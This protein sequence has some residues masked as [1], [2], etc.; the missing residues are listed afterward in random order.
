[1]YNLTYYTKY[2]GLRLHV[3]LHR[4]HFELKFTFLDTAD[5]LEE[6]EKKFANRK[7][8]KRK[9]Y[10]CYVVY[11]KCGNREAAKNIFFNL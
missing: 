10:Y 5:C 9:S 8:D 6:E 11:K 2:K 4:Q 1:M 3:I 7:L